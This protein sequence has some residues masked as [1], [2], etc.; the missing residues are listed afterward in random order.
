MKMVQQKEMLDPAIKG[1]INVLTAAKEA[2]VGRVVVTS[3]ISSMY[4]SP[5]WP[6]DRVRDEDSWTDLDYCKQKEVSTSL[7]LIRM[8]W[9]LI[10]I[11]VLSRQTQMQMQMQM[12]IGLICVVF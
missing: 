6:A 9:H 10:I 1:T 4:P 5:G 12:L 3:S 8:F 7:C 2:G 11:V